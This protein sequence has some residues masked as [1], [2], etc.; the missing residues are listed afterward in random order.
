MKYTLLIEHKG[1]QKVLVCGFWGLGDR[2]TEKDWWSSDVLVA[3]RINGI[4]W[5]QDLETAAKVRKVWSDYGLMVG[6]R[7]VDEDE[8]N[9]MI[10]AKVLA[11]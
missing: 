11:R 8:I 2:T 7:I 3:D 6:A 10:V 5:L 4:E 1:E 9:G